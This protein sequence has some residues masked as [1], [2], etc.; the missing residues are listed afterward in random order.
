MNDLVGKIL[1]SLKK[2]CENRDHNKIR[3][4]P[5]GGFFDCRRVLHVRAMT[6]QENSDLVACS[7]AQ[8]RL[9]P[10]FCCNLSGGDSL[11][12]SGNCREKLTGIFAKLRKKPW[13][14]KY[15]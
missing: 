12:Q 15:A 9:F 10:T 14:E 4:A 6:L 2:R 5:R 8:P 3:A 11:R 13:R 1:S 7:S